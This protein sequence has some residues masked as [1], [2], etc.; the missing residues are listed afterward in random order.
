[1]ILL[2]TEEKFHCSLRNKKHAITQEKYE[3]ETKNPFRKE[4]IIVLWLQAITRLFIRWYSTQKRLIA[5]ERKKLNHL[6][7]L[8]FK[9]RI[10][11][12]AFQPPLLNYRRNSIQNRHA[13]SRGNT[14]NSNRF[15]AFYDQQRDV[16]YLCEDM[17]DGVN[18]LSK[19]SSS[20]KTKRQPVRV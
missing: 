10:S 13:L 2:F 20:C 5:S 8:V 18:G 17:A 6:K 11:H 19:N 12:V 15:V 3:E 14:I 9:Y 7:I 1:M 16:C 4:R